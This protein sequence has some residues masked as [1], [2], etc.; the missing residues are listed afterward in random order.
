MNKSKGFT[1]I[2]LLV[3]IAIIGILSSVVLVSL[4]GTR[5]K[6][7]AA[8]FK[9][10][11]T[12]LYPALVSACDSTAI[13]GQPTLLAAVPGIAALGHHAVGTWVSSNCG[14]T[15]AGTFNVTF[16]PAP[17]PSGTC[18]LATISETGVVTT[19]DPC[20]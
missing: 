20:Q 11:M 2:E 1:L 10:E 14:T 3:V 19:P 13:T 9:S 18:T 7:Q 4:S 12:S 17:N 16:A 15:G 6:A 8:A 5:T